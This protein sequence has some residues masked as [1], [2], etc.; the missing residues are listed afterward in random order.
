MNVPS[1]TLPAESIDS[2]HYISKESEAILSNGNLNKTIENAAI[3]TLQTIQVDGN[4]FTIFYDTGCSDLVMRFKAIEKLGKRAVQEYK[5]PISI[6]GVGDL[7]IDSHRGIYQ[8]RLP[9]YNGRDAIR[10][11]P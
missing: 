10:H 7:K 11:V 2:N 1:I 4:R 9:L 6:G 5:G 3:Y 8:I